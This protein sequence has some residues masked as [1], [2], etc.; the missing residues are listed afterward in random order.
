MRAGGDVLVVTGTASGKSL[1]YVLPIIEMLSADPDATALL[2]FPTKALTQDD[3]QM[4]ID[5]VGV[6]TGRVL[7]CQKICSFVTVCPRLSI[8]SLGSAPCLLRAKA[9][10]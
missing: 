1:C 6:P 10:T 8:C 3:R 4:Q 2:L 9:L 5:D 7:S